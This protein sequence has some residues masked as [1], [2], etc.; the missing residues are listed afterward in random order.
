MGCTCSTTDKEIERTPDFSCFP[1]KYKNLQELQADL[2]REGLEGCNLIIGIDYTASNSKQGERSFNGQ[3]LH[4]VSSNPNPYQSVIR[5]LGST[6]AHFDED[7]LLPVFG[8]GDSTTKNT[9]VFPFYPD[10]DCHGFEEVLTRYNEITPT[11]TLSGPTNFAPLIYKACDIVR[12]NG[13]N[14][15]HILVIICDGQVNSEKDTSDAI[16]YASNF[17]LSIICV[18]VGDGPWHVMETFDDRLPKRKFDNFQFVDYH[19]V[20]KHAQNKA[21][22]FAHSALMEVPL[23]YK[24]IKALGL[25]GKQTAP[26]P[27][28]PAVAAVGR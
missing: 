23:Q 7:N 16:V 28:R 2:E 12:Q 18:G 25:I 9:S 19:K 5:I 27:T 8:F 15:Y 10:R 22:S 24:A 1:D 14:E 26:A 13:R 3:N 20:I 17:S 11:L 6:L 4:L 21:T